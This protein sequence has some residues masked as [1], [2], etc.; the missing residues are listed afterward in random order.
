MWLPEA[1]FKREDREK[2]SEASTPAPHSGGGGVEI[3][4]SECLSLDSGN[5]SSTERFAL[6]S[7]RGMILHYAKHRHLAGTARA[8]VSMKYLSI[9][10][11]LTL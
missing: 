4:V 11:D 10:E 8:Q 5:Q 3:Q 7:R 1:D 9:I 2:A 6:C